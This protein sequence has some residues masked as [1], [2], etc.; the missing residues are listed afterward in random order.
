[1][2]NAVESKE[3]NRF[4]E[5]ELQNP[6]TVT[7]RRALLRFYHK[8]AAKDQVDTKR[9]QRVNETYCDKL[10]ST[11]AGKAVQNSE[12]LVNKSGRKIRSHHVERS[13]KDT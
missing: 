11:V 1:M 6:M 13:T 3:S 10:G 7:R 9:S 4:F 2:R 5:L 12:K 8:R